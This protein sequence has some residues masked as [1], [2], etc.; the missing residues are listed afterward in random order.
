[1]PLGEFRDFDDCVAKNQDKENPEAFCGFLKN[2]IEGAVADANQE[3]KYKVASADFFQRDGKN[4]AKF[5][6]ISDAENLKGWKVADGTVSQFI[7]TFK[8]RPFISEPELAHFGA[9]FMPLHEVMQKQEEFRIGNINEVQF[10]EKNQTATAIVE[11]EN[12]PAAQQAWNDMQA[13]KAFY[14]S[15][16]V[17]GMSIDG[18]NGPIF[19][20]WFGLHLARVKNPA[21]GALHATI[22]GTCSGPEA[23][24]V[25]RLLASAAL[26]ITPYKKPCTQFPQMATASTMNDG[27]KGGVISAKERQNPM[28]SKP[29]VEPLTAA[30]H[31]DETEE[32][33]KKRLESENASLRKQVAALKTAQEDPPAEP[34]EPSTP[35]TP[36]AVMEEVKV[37]KEQLAV[38]EEEEIAVIVEEIMEIKAELDTGPAPEEPEAVE[39]ASAEYKKKGLAN[40]KIIRDEL[41]PVVASVKEFAKQIASKT[42][43]RIIKT[44]D[45]V[46][47]MSQ[48]SASDDNP[49]D[50]RE[51]IQALG[52][53]L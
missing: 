7:Q 47:Q 6:L 46:N 50:A 13:G 32:E 1:M 34:A 15:P 22:K 41:K 33:K 26:S 18:Q 12:T 4:F 2:K 27:G 52:R 48:A 42:G 31:P 19:T 45:E 40:L 49:E 17:A 35:S 36:E 3:W 39:Q 20:E 43:T 30:E 14:V 16:A 24:C 8:D 5:F 37:L 25:N 44:P 53:T 21:Y 29:R 9:D 28:T 10:N 11:F 51:A 38:K 23:S